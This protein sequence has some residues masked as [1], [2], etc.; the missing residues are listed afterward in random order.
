MNFGGSRLGFWWRWPPGLPDRKLSS[1]KVLVFYDPYT[2]GPGGNTDYYNSGDVNPGTD[3]WPVIQ[4]QEISL[5][6]QPEL[7]VG[8]NNLPSNMIQYSHIWDIGYASP[9]YGN[10]TL[11]PTTLLTSYLQQGG[12]MFMLGENS[13]FTPRDDTIELFI[14]GLG[15]PLP[16]TG[17]TYL[18]QFS[19]TIASEFLIANNNNSIYWGNPGEFTSYGTGT[20]IT[21]G[22]GYGP[23]AVMWKT[24]SLPAAPKGA[25]VAVLDINFFGSTYAPEFYDPDFVDNLSLMLNQL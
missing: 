9:Y 19:Q 13:A 18:P 7:I 10:P 12:A 24:G 4:A 17:S 6:F 15:S 3:V 22:G 20:P 2:N 11:N 23:V 25:V 14:Y 1:N 8:Y 16:T 5:G 21:T